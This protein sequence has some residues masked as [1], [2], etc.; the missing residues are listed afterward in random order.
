MT[1]KLAFI[2]D[3]KGVFLK[4]TPPGHAHEGPKSVVRVECVVHAHGW[5]DSD[6]KLLRILVVKAD[7]I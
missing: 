5:I 4:D 1:N 6:N 3:K 2:L 7:D